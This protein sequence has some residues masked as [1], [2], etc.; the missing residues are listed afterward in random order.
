MAVWHCT[1]ICTFQNT[2][3]QLNSTWILVKIVVKKRFP[4]WVRPHL[5]GPSCQKIGHPPKEE[6]FSLEE[7]LKALISGFFFESLENFR[8]LLSFPQ[9]GGCLLFVVFFR[10]SLEGLGEVDFSEGPPHLAL[11]PSFSQTR[12]FFGSD[13]FLL[14][15]RVEKNCFRN[16]PVPKKGYDFDFTFGC[17]KTTLFFI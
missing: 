12:F 3:L 8:F 15:T 10:W 1:H 9:G 4:S 16:S 7:S 17:L 5:L 13:L 6:I 2:W 11:R 14:R